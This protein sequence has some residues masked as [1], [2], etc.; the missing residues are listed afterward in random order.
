M[1]GLNSKNKNIKGGGPPKRG[2]HI[3]RLNIECLSGFFLTWK[4]TMKIV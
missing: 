4:N 2:N 3:R 1:E